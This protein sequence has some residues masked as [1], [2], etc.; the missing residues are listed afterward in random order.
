MCVCVGAAAAHANASAIAEQLGQQRLRAEKWKERCKRL[1]G[2]LALMNASG[3]AREA[4]ASERLL[5]AGRHVDDEL[6][7]C[8]AELSR[9]SLLSV[10]PFCLR[11]SAPRNLM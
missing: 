4:A 2:Q 3:A 11:R 7:R 1:G 10:L 8:K 6:R 5:E 9:Y